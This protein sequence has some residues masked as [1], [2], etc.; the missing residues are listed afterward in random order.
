LRE[1]SDIQIIVTGSMVGHALKVAE[2]LESEGISS[3]VTNMH[4]VKP[5]DDSAIELN[6]RM[7]V[8]LEEHN[9]KGGLG[10]AVSEELATYPQHPKLLKLGI[11]DTFMPVGSYAYLLEQADLSIEKIKEKIIVN[12]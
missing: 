4:T 2:A 10:S 8:T 5:L 9:V 11:N 7:I 12:L 6:K 1:G 3:S